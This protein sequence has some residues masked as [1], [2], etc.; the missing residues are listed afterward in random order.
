MRYYAATG[1]YLGV[2][3]DGGVWGY[4][5]FTNN[6]LR[7]YGKMS[8]YTCL[9]SPG[10]CEPRPAVCKTE[11]STGFTGDL[12]A[13]YPDAGGDADGSGSD[14][15]SA[16]VGGSEGKVLGGRIKVIRLLDGVT[17][18]EGITDSQLGLT[19]IKWCKSDM[20]VMLEMTGAPGSKYFDE[21]VNDLVD[22]PPTQRL[23]ALVDR[24]DENVG[25]SALTEA[26]Y[27]YVMNN[28]VNDPAPIEAGVKPLV[29]DGIPIG[30]SIAQ[31]QHANERVLREVNRHFTNS[32]GQASIKALATPVDKTSSASAIPQNRYGRMAVATAGF[33]EAAGAYGNDSAPALRFTRSIA[34]DLADGKID[35]ATFGRL[36]KPSTDPKSYTA[37]SASR[38]WTIGS[39]LFAAKF[40]IDTRG[41]FEKILSA[42]NAQDLWVN[43]CS[44]KRLFKDLNGGIYL[45]PFGIL[46]YTAPPYDPATCLP[47]TI[48][49]GDPEINYSPPKFGYFT[50]ERVREVGARSTNDG[51]ISFWIDVDGGVSGI[52]NAGCSMFGDGVLKDSFAIVPKRVVGLPKV[53]S[54]VSNLR[55]H[56][57]IGVDGHLYAWGEPNSSGALGLP[58]ALAKTCSRLA[59]DMDPA[60]ESSFNYRGPYPPNGIVQVKTVPVPVKVPGLS[61]VVS[62]F[63]GPYANVALTAEGKVYEWGC[64][65]SGHHCV[66]ETPAVYPHLDS[67]KAIA[68]GVAVTYAIRS[69]GTLWIWGANDA[70]LPVNYGFEGPI[71]IAKKVPGIEGAVDVRSGNFTAVLK[72]N[73]ELILWGAQQG[74]FGFP[75]RRLAPTAW[76]KIKVSNPIDPSNDTPPKAVRLLQ[77]KESITYLGVDGYVY[78]FYSVAGFIW[79]RSELPSSLGF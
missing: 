52:G 77:S 36:G 64:S 19:T 43:M 41:N 39:G 47:A 26:A 15:G 33:V 72:D 16:G 60:P 1:N 14:G 20:P 69:D 37:Q 38:E 12:N 9:V 75:E 2:D 66:G 44:D 50:V 49:P 65:S 24:F 70:I 11:L 4:G 48:Q 7:S 18:G 62:V 29:S 57:A 17:L 30:L 22:F 32:L 23:R 53:A 45:K 78:T 46:K 54:M 42:V 6:T 28:I 25:V 76:N 40:A 68:Q 73:Q 51:A 5:P 10:L 61:N 67:V 31:V 34:V 79:T 63:A 8:G 3:D 35:G 59:Q 21:A 13:T 56:L 55:S 27:M 58:L 74:V 71:L